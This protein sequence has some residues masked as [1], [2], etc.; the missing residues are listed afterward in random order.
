MNESKKYKLGF[1]LAIISAILAAISLLVHF[2][3]KRKP[4]PGDDFKDGRFF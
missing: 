2:S 1:L 4:K 3:Q